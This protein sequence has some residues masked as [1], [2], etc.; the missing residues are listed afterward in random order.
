MRACDMAE[1]NVVAAAHAQP[2]RWGDWENFS[3]WGGTTP[4]PFPEGSLAGDTHPEI[5]PHFR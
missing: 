1:L 3:H 5:V 2:L 4:T